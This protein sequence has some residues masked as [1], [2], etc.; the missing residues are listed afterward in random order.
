MYVLR[1]LR[2]HRLAG[3]VDNFLD[4]SFLADGTTTLRRYLRS[5]LGL[6]PLG[7][8]TE[9]NVA[10]DTSGTWQAPWWASDGGSTGEAATK[11]ELSDQERLEII[12]MLSGE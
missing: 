8:E 11:P 5:E 10:P 4:D 3:S 9:S 2:A 6:S 1:C 7:E 12:A